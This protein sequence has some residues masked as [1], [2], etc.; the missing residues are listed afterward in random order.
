MLQGDD[1]GYAVGCA[2]G[3]SERGIC[4]GAS[5]GDCAAAVAGRMPPAAVQRLRG[6]DGGT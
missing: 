6:C 1:A 2:G 4:C 5:G 3:D